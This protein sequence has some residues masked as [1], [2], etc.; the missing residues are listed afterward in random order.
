[1]SHPSAQF[2]SVTHT[3]SAD[4]KFFDALMAHPSSEAFAE[5]SVWY[6][7][8]QKYLNDIQ[9]SLAEAGEPHGETYKI[10]VVSMLGG[11]AQALSMVMYLSARGIIHEAAAA[12]RRALEFLGVASHLVADPAKAKFLSLWR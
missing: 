12:G 8:L 1:M 3:F 6:T 10:W 5:M 11:M 2:E 4:A 9:E 7:W